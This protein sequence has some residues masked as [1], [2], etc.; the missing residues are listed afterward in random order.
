MTPNDIL[1]KYFNYSNFR[2]GQE[3]IIAGI[4]KGDNVLAIL[5]TSAGKSIC[6]QVPALMGSSFSIVISPLIAL[7]K[8]QVDALNKKEQIAAFIN[9]TL[10]YSEGEKVLNDV[11]SGKI[12]ILYAAPEKL[13]NRQFTERIK[14]LNPS[15]L[16]VD[17]AHCISEW[18]HNFRPS[19]RKIREFCE[20]IEVDKISAFTA[21]ATPEVREDI[22]NQLNFIKPKIFVKGFERGNLHLNIL[23]T[24]HKKEQ[25][26][27]LIKKYETPVIIYTSTRKNAEE[28]AGY[29]NTHGYNSQYYHA[30]LAPELRRI[31]QDDFINDNIK[32]IAATNAFGMGIDKKDIRLII[33]YN[34]PGTIE[35][36]Y[37][38]MGRA[39]RDGLDSNIF[40]LYEERDRH[41]QEF[42]INNSYPSRQQIEYAY[43]SFCNYSGI[44]LG[45]IGDKE[46]PLDK[47]L[48]LL[49]ARENISKG[50]LNSI[51]NLLTDAGYLN[52]NSEFDKSHFVKFIIPKYELRKYVDR[53]AGDSLKDIILILMREHGSEI[54]TTKK[55]INISQLSSMLGT[56]NN[57]II[58]LLENL[59]NI[60]IIDY[61][62]P[63]LFPSVKLSSTRVKSE[64][65]IIDFNSITLRKKHAYDKLNQMMNFV[66][67]ENCRMEFILNYFGERTENHKC[68]NCDVC[69]GRAEVL[70]SS[71]DYLEE[72]IIDTLHELKSS[73]KMFHLINILLG[74]SRSP[75]FKK[76]SSYGTCVHFS[77]E[78]VQTAID[79]LISKG[80]ISNFNQTLS[81]TEE[82]L[83]RY[84]S[85]P[86]EEDEI[87]PEKSG[88]ESE[89]ELFNLLRQAR[90]GASSKFAQ[91][92]NIICPDNLLRKIAKE[93]PSTPSNLLSVEGFTQ[94][95]YNKVGEDFLN[96][97][98]E[99]ESNKEDEAAISKKE[100]PQNISIILKLVKKG[101]GLKD[102]SSLTKLP[103]AVVSVQIE[104]LLEF[105]PDLNINSLFDK[106]ELELIESQMDNEILEMKELKQ[107]LPASIS[108][109]KIRIAL[110]KR[111]VNR[112][113]EI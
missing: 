14:S 7:M 42:F 27:E 62:K 50:L 72:I 54:F 5:P 8:D 76:L 36:Y 26:L 92:A 9:S 80:F 30:G 75:G 44:A 32:I 66:F 93:K 48:L 99:F 29:L 77:K 70:N 106:G 39:G 111:R 15:Y 38:E 91:T 31:I 71:I 43:D 4:L 6:Y 94:R 112:G 101:Y 58:E 59:A 52:K 12:K 113:K 84:T 3:E 34:M 67:T 65:L 45:N 11:S 24:K 51:I 46:I 41:I 1:I 68:G 95:M 47:N 110:A 100:L 60:G 10:D 57:V 96:I 35:N 73:L 87:I 33:H 89:L 56:A 88:Y 63:T 53:I 102:L 79:V 23:R 22:V 86:Q 82:A 16:F 18:G 108:Y 40:L 104:T 17:E 61:D 81:I 64:E 20:Y 25:T 105:I 55:R 49:L 69:T 78:E 13:A 109:G 90:K 83:K 21:T 103:E 98:K 97:I 85:I 107:Q 74:T 28:I 19:Y 2:P 37:Q